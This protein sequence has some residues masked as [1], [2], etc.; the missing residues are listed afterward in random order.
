MAPQLVMIITVIA[1]II[2]IIII[3]NYCTDYRKNAGV[4]QLAK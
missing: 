1:I 2:I 3:K 4:L